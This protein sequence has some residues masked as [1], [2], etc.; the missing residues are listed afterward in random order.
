MEW[1]VV[2][3]QPKFTKPTLAT[4]GGRRLNMYTEIQLSI[5][6]DD[7]SKMGATRRGL[8]VTLAPERCLHQASDDGCP[9]RFPALF[10]HL[11]EYF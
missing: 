6:L 7:G 3:S 10:S 4:T 11:S 2:V 9:L 5:A 1:S 8:F